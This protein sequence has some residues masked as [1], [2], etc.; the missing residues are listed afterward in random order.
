M[1]NS[2]GFVTSILRGV[3]ELFWMNKGHC[4]DVVFLVRLNRIV[5]AK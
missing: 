3:E 5:R 2:E 1:V 4:D